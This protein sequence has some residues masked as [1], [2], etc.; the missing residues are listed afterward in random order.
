MKELKALR[1]F[2]YNGKSYAK[3][4]LF[5]TDERNA[6]YLTGRGLAVYVSIAP[7]TPVTTPIVQPKKTDVPISAGE[8][9]ML[10]RETVRKPRKGK[11]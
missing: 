9:K 4:Q 6:A 11:K 8:N 3:N 5:T 1:P 10:K 2:N 7:G